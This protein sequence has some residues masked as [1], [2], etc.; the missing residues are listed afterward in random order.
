MLDGFSPGGLPGVK[1]RP[2]KSSDVA[3]FYDIL[4][5]AV[6]LFSTCVTSKPQAQA[7]WSYAGKF[8]I[9]RPRLHPRFDLGPGAHRKISDSRSTKQERRPASEYLS[10][11]EAQT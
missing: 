5:V 10:S 1:P 3:T 7:G 2:Y 6:K 8:L 11:D 9:N 4:H